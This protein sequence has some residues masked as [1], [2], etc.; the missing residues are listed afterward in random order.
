MTRAVAVVQGKDKISNVKWMERKE[1][2]TMLMERI[3]RYD[4]IWTSRAT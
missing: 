2:F 3:R 1:V 4:T